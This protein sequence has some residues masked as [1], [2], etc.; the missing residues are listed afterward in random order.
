MR[1]FH[2]AAAPLLGAILTT[3]PFAAGAGSKD[4]DQ[5]VI[6]RGRYM[7]LVGGC[8]DCHTPGY[9]MNDGKIP[10]K[11]WLVGDQLGYRGG[12]GTTYPTNLRRYFARTSEAEWLHAAHKG[13]FRPP[14]PG[15]ALRAMSDKDLRA[16]YRFVRSLGPAGPE[17]PA[18]Q[19]P[20]TQ[21]AG[22]VVLFPMPPG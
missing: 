6:E 14:M 19:S 1:L 18:Y 21:P 10:E 8:N 13:V 16:V 17:V 11:D 5:K 12:W 3:L 4:A 9:A 20:E 7:V 15:P 2:T 22:P